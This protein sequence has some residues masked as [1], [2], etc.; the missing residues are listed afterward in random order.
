MQYSK[1]TLSY[2]ITQGS[3]CYSQ[4]ASLPTSCIFS[5]KPWLKA[6]TVSLVRNSSI[7]PWLPLLEPIDT[8]TAVVGQE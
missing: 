5:S 6:A 4:D 7:E 2:S 1:C 8:R 3:V